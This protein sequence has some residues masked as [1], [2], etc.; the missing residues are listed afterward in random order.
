MVDNSKEWLINN[1]INNRSSS[2]GKNTYF[3]SIP[4][5]KN[6]INDLGSDY[7]EKI[8]NT[9]YKDK[10]NKSITKCVLNEYNLTNAAKIRR[11]SLFKNQALKE[12]ESKLTKIK[13]IKPDNT[14]LK[15]KISLNIEPIRYSIQEKCINRINTRVSLDLD[16]NFNNKYK[17][18]SIFI[19]QNSIKKLMNIWKSEVNNR[20]SGGL[21]KRSAV[22]LK[23]IQTKIRSSKNLFGNIYEKYKLGIYETLKKTGYFQRSEKFIIKIKILHLFLAIFS[24]LS[25]LLEYF[26]NQEYVSLSWEY[27]TSNKNFNKRSITDYFIITKRKISSKENTIRSFNIICSFFCLGLFLFIRSLKYQLIRIQKN[28][29]TKIGNY[30]NKYNWVPA[31][32]KTSFNSNSNFDNIGLSVEENIISQN[33][34]TN[35]NKTQFIIECLIN[36]I[37]IPPGVNR[38][39]IGQYYNTIYVY[40]LNSIFLII[41]FMKLFNIYKAILYLSSLNNTFYKVICQ[42]N[43]VN[44]NYK[45]ILKYI[46]KHYPISFVVV[47]FIIIILGF[48][49]VIYS[50]EYFS[51]S[52]K[53]EESDYRDNY[54]FKHFNNCVKVCLSL[55]LRQ[56]FIFFGN[57][58]FFGIIFLIGLTFCMCLVAYFFY[59][60]HNLIEMS[61]EEE[62]AYSKLIKLFNP[63]NKE[64]KA[65]NLIV[66]FILLKKLYK[67]NDILLNEYVLKK[68]IETK[69]I[70]IKLDQELYDYN[71]RYS[72]T[73]QSSCYNEKQIKEQIINDEKNIEKKKFIKFLEN[74]C[75]L[76]MKFTN[77]TRNF[78]N[79][80]K[81]ARNYS[82]SFNDVLRTV[83]DKLK[84]NLNNLNTQLDIVINQEFKFHSFINLEENIN[85]KIKKM[86]KYQKI[87]NEYLL[88]QYNKLLIDNQKEK[89]R[90]KEKGK[91]KKK[92]KLKVMELVAKMNKQS[93]F[94]RKRNCDTPK[95]TKKVYT[96]D[97]NSTNSM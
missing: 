20:E 65:S 21:N 50:I 26:D 25:I 70:N 37:F 7:V 42:S 15:R 59:Y 81:I 24:L 93:L 56:M 46:V 91:E 16:Q 60:I 64:H 90:E 27:L 44:L 82:L 13:Q 14:I 61:P 43:L 80:L 51:I 28:K 84:I 39:F 89:E 66:T 63:E 49:S 41:T 69:R 30:N 87:L 72:A 58:T 57:N 17:K 78:G 67:D 6:E 23:F 53:Y 22:K 47:N 79:K 48:S 88:L 2:F 32:R 9:E 74:K 38:V 29:N 83:K 1:N 34:T 11:H 96:F 77:E 95:Y 92:K 68:E 76:K 45:F 12:Y 71:K 35:E 55:I 54:S 18:K 62:K 31:K 19:G 73:K 5:V 94:E 10:S 8:N 4:E 52:I 75:I 33:I 97:F 36:I 3:E 86:N 85:K 40:S